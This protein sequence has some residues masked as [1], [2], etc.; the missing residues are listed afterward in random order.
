MYLYGTIRTY[1]EAASSGQP[2]PGGGSVAALAGALGMTMGCMAANF[3]VGK[4]KF[5]AVESE[6]Q[7]LLAASLRARDELLRLMDE[8]TKAYAAVSAAYALPKETPEQAAARTHAI[9][10]ALIVAMDSPLQVVRTCRSALEP[11][12]RL[13]EIANPNLISDVGV[14]AIL[15]EAA[16]RAAKLNVEINL[17]SLEDQALSSAT[18]N[19]IVRAAEE[20]RALARQTMEKVVRAIGG[21]L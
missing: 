10:K 3:T 4:K 5:K 2:T 1:S 6:V 20:A 7:Q 13:A 18:R 17:Q 16:L 21:T 11:I 15:A 19:E 9:Q 12:A 8:D 14:A